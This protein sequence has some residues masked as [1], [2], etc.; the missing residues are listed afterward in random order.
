MVQG[1]LKS[2]VMDKIEETRRLLGLDVV[3]RRLDGDRATSENT[4]LLKLL[5]M[6]CHSDMSELLVTV[7]EQCWRLGWL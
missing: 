2:K 5:D 7:A 3:V 1:Q 6:V 4:P